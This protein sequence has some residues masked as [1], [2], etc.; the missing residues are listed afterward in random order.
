MITGSAR[1][2]F[3]KNNQL[4]P[5]IEF[6]NTFNPPFQF[7]YEVFRIVD[8][9]P[10]FVEDH[11]NRFWH[12]ANLVQIDPGIS[13]HDLLSQ[14]FRVIEANPEGDG[15]M[16]IVFYHHV[17]THPQ[18]FV[19]YTPHQ[20]P[21]DQQFKMGVKV[22]SLFAERNQPNAKVMDTGLRNAANELKSVEQAYEILLLNKEGFITEGSRSNVFFIKKNILITPPLGTVLPGV[23]RKH[24]IELAGKN[25]IDF[26]EEF[27]KQS[28]LTHMEA[29]FISGTSRQ[30]LPVKS[31]DEIQFKT[32][33]PI[34][35][36]LQEA[37]INEVQ[38]Y[39]TERKTH[40]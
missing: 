22:V 30:V 24:I 23:T 37:F 14:V 17:T 33:H 7:I 5:V 27:V 34:V 19:F 13:R 12:T 32:D 6:E 39:I 26:C 29:V 40:K 28:D 2:Y 9:I 11:F 15:N 36:L 1:Q 31:I 10:L 8:N 4:L 3:I 25:N 20:Y 21:T 16:Q 18:L 38:K 35:H